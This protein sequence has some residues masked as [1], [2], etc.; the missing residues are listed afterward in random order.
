MGLSR[1]VSE[2]AIS[3]ENRKNF[4]TPLYFA[5]SLKGFPLELGIGAEAKKTRMTGLPGRERSLPIS[6]AV[7]IQ[8]TKV[9]DRHRAT[10]KTA[11]A[12]AI[13]IAS[14]GKKGRAV[15]RSAARGP[16]GHARDTCRA[17]SNAKFS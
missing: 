4:P 12:Y 17:F 7:W 9:T 13:R 11:R 3:V 16:P 2:T 1:T 8:S 6:S 10:A 15:Q 14:R 5:P